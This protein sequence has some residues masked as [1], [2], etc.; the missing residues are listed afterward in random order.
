MNAS[1]IASALAARAEDVCRHY[2]PGGRRQGR[3]WV[4]GD[5]DGNKGRSLY[6]RLTPP[7]TPGKWN[8]AATSEHGDLLDIV[9]HRSRTHSLHG[10]IDEARRFLSL[11]APSPAATH[12]DTYDSIAAA[13]RLW[14]HCTPLRNTHAEA[15]LQARGIAPRPLPAL[16][17]HPALR[18]REGESVRNMP[19]LV[20]AVTARDGT[21]L[22]VQRTWLDATKPAKASVTSPRKALGSI[23]GLTV[24]LAPHPSG[25]LVVG[26]GIETV[27]S[28]LT[29]VPGIAAAAALSAGSLAA[30][31]PPPRTSR[32]FIAADRDPEGE[33][34]ANRLAA[35][36]HQLGIP[37]TVILP[38]R[39]D[40]NE[41]LTAL[42]EDVLATRL[43]RLLHADA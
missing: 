12:D 37:T 24:R 3:Y 17:Y 31:T 42:G 25:A 22:G 7:G 27:L 26:E 6:V 4:A 9:R 8:D 11:P 16:R 32:L 21:L 15:Y 18:Y 1:A 38:E 39:G 14:Q 43:R 2:L 36:V 28:I 29:A 20:A 35:R 40:F 33:S 30:F 5:I 10:A 41:D 23:H 34:A 19:A 13:R